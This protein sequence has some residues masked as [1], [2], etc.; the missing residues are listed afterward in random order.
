MSVSIRPVDP[1]ADRAELLSVLQDNLPALPHARRFEWLYRDNPDG[2]AWSWFALDKNAGRVVGTTSVFPRSIWVNGRLQLCGQVGDFAI[3]PSHRS[4]G[5]AVLVQRATFQPVDAGQ[6]CFCYDCPPHDAGMSTFR[7]I[8]LKPNCVVQRCALPLRIDEHLRKRLGFSFPVLAVAGNAVWQLWR[9]TGKT[10]HGLEITEHSGRFSDEF[11]ALDRA[12]NSSNAVRACRGAAQLNWRYRD[13]PL[14]TYDVLTAR[15]QGTLSGFVVFQLSARKITIV[16][17]IGAE[18]PEV[19]LALLNTVAHK[20]G[21]SRDTM[22]ACVSSESDAAAP[23]SRAGFRTRGVAAHI[24]AYA[25]PRS[26]MSTFF[27]TNVRWKFNGAEI[28][29]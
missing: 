18:S 26:E 8:G 22:E 11:T 5:P 2:P 12:M 3:S 23:L 17:L 7:R 6:L 15:S 13:D 21:A 19:A 24:V 16:D 4:L 29:A 28:R 10:V 14:N 25:L 9:R 27:E 20:Y 1:D